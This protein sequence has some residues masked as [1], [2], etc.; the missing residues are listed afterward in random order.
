VSGVPKVESI[1]RMKE[2]KARRVTP[3]PEAGR[4]RRPDRRRRPSRRRQERGGGRVFRAREVGD[5]RTT[6]AERPGVQPGRPPTAPRR[7]AEAQ[8]RFCGAS[9]SGAAQR[10]TLPS[11][12]F[13]RARSLGAE[14]LACRLASSATGMTSP[15]RLGRTPARG[16]RLRA[17][18]RRASNAAEGRPRPGAAAPPTTHPPTHGATARRRRS[19]YGSTDH[20]G[21]GDIPRAA[22]SSLELRMASQS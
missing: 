17:R 5:Q 20:A 11:P 6:V 10:R 7:T 16:T 2:S 3:R 8:P 21:T 1:Q 12:A 15:E 9:T 18:L 13:S 19:G 14:G 4:S 22:P